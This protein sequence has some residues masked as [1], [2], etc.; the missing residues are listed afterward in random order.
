MRTRVPHAFQRIVLAKQA[1][2]RTTRPENERGPKGRCQ[3]EQSL[4]HDES[5]RFEAR[6]NGR[7]GLEFLIAFFRMVENEIAQP[8]Q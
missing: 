5:M 8:K 7:I 1:D 6:R 3:T 4:I 2:S